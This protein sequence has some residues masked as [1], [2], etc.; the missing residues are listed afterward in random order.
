M[1]EASFFMNPGLATKYHLV[2]PASAGSICGLQALAQQT[3]EPA[4]EVRVS[5]RCKR[6][7]RCDGPWKV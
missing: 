3:F 5:M 7:C 6:C 4:A 1:R 2:D